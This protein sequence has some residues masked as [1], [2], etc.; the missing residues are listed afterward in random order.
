[1]SKSSEQDLRN[2]P[3]ATQ[4]RN[5]HQGAQEVFAPSA[6]LDTSLLDSNSDK[7]VSP[8]AAT[9]QKTH[10][11]RRACDE[12]RGRKIR[13]DGGH[14]CLHCSAL[15]LDC[16]YDQPDK[17]STRLSRR[18][19]EDLASKL[20]RARNLLRALAPNLDLDDPHLDKTVLSKLQLP[21]S[22]MKSPAST[23]A[24]PSESPHHTPHC[25]AS[26]EQ[27]S[28]LATVLEETGRLDL[29]DMGNWNYQS[30]GSS[31]AFVRRLGERFG[32]MSDL[33]IED[34]TTNL[35]LRGTS[36]IFESP[37]RLMNPAFEDSSREFISLPPRE[38]AIELATILALGY[39]FSCNERAHF[40]YTHAI[41][42]GAA[43][44]AAL[45]MGLHR[46]QP[47]EMD[48][49]ER[50]TRK[51]L[52]WTIRTLETYII[53]IL[54][55]PRTISDDDIDQEMPCEI[56][57]EYITKEGIFPMP[58]GRISL[59][60]ASNAHIRLA[61]IL[62]R[63]ST[64]VY[65]AKRMQREASQKTRAYVVNNAKV[66]E[67]E[68]DLRNW[69]TSLPTHLQPG[70][71]SSKDLTRAQH[72]LRLAFTH[73]Q[74]TLYKP[75]LH[76]ISQSRVDDLTSNQCYAYA[77]ACVDVGRNTIYNA[78]Q[79]EKQDILTGPYWFSIY[80]TFCATLALTFNVWENAE[81]EN[82]LGT[83]KDAEYGRH[84]LTRLAYQST[85]AESLSETL[86]HAT[87]KLIPQRKR[88][89]S[90]SRP[91]L[92]GAQ[93]QNIP[94]QNG[95]SATDAHYLRQ[96][97]IVRN[98]PLDV[99]PGD[100]NSNLDSTHWISSQTLNAPSPLTTRFLG[101]DSIEDVFGPA[102]LTP[103]N[104]WPES[105]YPRTDLQLNLGL[106]SPTF[107]MDLSDPTSPHTFS[108]LDQ[109]VSMLNLD[110][111]GATGTVLDQ[112]PHI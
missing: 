84:V 18:E 38:V 112:F 51:R 63:V 24:K 27:D 77:A 67:V 54:G 44:A 92:M 48:S 52:F 31:S 2:D 15:N 40:G 74:I 68:N 34:K 8:E 14:P 12:C 91:N 64:D 57:D 16:S 25:P 7:L 102:Q 83:I 20:Q 88:P 78:R 3:G 56:D 75:F 1:M 9:A 103:G 65:P 61:C 105:S 47:A 58:E 90:P 85:A 108:S 26:P 106:G 37:N 10:R 4:E 62:G 5:T 53:A 93:Q 86:G 69:M 111:D 80:T 109:Y 32:N 98:D 22:H 43:M 60:T 73:V 89:Q 97:S 55:L 107:G 94:V 95:H 6:A 39:L 101:P 35:R 33:S 41:S 30:H 81:V 46:S 36:D 19:V 96:R 104:N 29:D 82:A 21:I 45:Q 87:L 66:R 17:R 50:E 99:T 28:N 110:Y 100:L 59:I 79:M 23:G 70:P 13:C 72:L 76:Y 42:E 71:A 49:V 11:A